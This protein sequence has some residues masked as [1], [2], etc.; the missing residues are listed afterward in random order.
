M[1]NRKKY[2]SEEKFFYHRSRAGNCS[3]YGLK[4][5]G[6]KHCYSEGFQ[7]AFG[8]HDNTH[9]MTSEFG[10]RSG[11]AYALGYKRGR[12]AAWEYQQRTGNQPLSLATEY[13][14]KKD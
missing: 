11:R 14:R 8:G 12:K 7:E 6:P 10:K 4:Y 2:S 3:K 9:G 5:G 1:K 13:Y